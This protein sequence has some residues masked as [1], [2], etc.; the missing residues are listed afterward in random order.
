LASKQ[1]SFQ[2][3]RFKFQHDYA[4]SPPDSPDVPLPP[5]VKSRWDSLWNPRR[6]KA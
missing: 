1:K 6:R 5:P 4:A 3:L 2:R